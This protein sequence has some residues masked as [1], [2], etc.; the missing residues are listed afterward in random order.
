MA[1]MSIFLEAIMKRCYSSSVRDEMFEKFSIKFLN[2]VV[3]KPQSF[4]F[5]AILDLSLS[6]L[7][8]FG[9]FL[10]L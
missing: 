8:L 4:T 6:A 5:E 10:P 2:F 1:S 3:C 9:V 7:P